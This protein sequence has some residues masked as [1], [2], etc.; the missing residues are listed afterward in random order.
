[1]ERSCVT[2][3]GIKIKKLDILSGLYNDNPYAQ[4]KGQTFLGF[5][6]LFDQI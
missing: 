1:M 6:L 3:I 5:F 2:N 4:N